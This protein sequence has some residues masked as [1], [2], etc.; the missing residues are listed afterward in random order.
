MTPS[1][2]LCL[3]VAAGGAVGCALR[4]SAGEVA[5]DGSGFPWTTFVINLTGTLLLALLPVVAAVR[6]SPALT[7]ALGP[8]LLGGWTTLSAWSEQTRALLADD[9][10]VL[11]TA[12]AGG[13][14]GACLLAVA[15]V[16]ALAPRPE[17]ADA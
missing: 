15:L 1:A 14:L 9:R 8:G 5:P 6:R 11:A 7:A 10:V 16:D 4:W 13:T 12:Y 17:V 3:C 2:R